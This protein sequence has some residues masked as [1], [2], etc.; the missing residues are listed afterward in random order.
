MRR[1]DTAVREPFEP[2]EAGD[3]DVRAGYACAS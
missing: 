2:L 3:A 1:A